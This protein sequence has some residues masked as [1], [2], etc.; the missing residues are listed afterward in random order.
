MAAGA[1][2]SMEEIMRKEIT[3]QLADGTEK[4]IPFLANGGTAVRFRNVFQKELLAS[5]SGIANT[6]GSEGLSALI[7]MAEDSDGQGDMDIALDDL[8]GDTL[9]IF[10]RIAGSGELDTVSK[11]AYIMNRAAE[12][13]DMRT[14][15]VEG[16]LDWLEQFETLEF[17]THALDIIGIYMSNRVT[18][19]SPKKDTAQLTEM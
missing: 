19:A 7:K 15:D 5:I 9:Q 8:D 1:F 10:L 13:A 12:G 2:W 16:Y 6:V 17:L 14:L 3:L 11:L 18:T 4:A